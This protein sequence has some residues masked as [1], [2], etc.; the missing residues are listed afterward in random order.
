VVWA[1][2]REMLER[3]LELSGYR[4]QK[5]AEAEKERSRQRLDR[6]YAFGVEVSRIT[7]NLS[8]RELDKACNEPR[9][10]MVDG[11]CAST[12]CCGGGELC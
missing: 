7:G 10:I 12:A 11:S 8:N 1:V 4:E 3:T 9:F 6:E 2:N 5:Q